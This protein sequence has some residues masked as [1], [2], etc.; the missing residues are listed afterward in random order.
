[1]TDNLTQE[2]SPRLEMPAE[3]SVQ[4][5]PQ[6]SAPAGSVR[7]SCHDSPYLSCIQP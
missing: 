4:V 7:I 3:A 6:R 5:A 1:M 2:E